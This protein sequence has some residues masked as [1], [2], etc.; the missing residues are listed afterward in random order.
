MASRWARFK[1]AMYWIHRWTGIG[2]CVLMALWF[3]SG[4]VMLFVGYPKL[5]PWERLHNMPALSQQCC[6]AFDVLGSEDL[7]AVSA[8]EFRLTT[9]DGTP[10]YRVLRRD[11]SYVVFD[12]MTGARRAAV[13]AP[14]SLRAAGD[15]IAVASAPARASA[16]YLGMV[17]EDTWTHSG[18]LN[19]HRPLHRVQLADA[20][21]T[22]V[23]VSSR[24]GEVVMDAPLFQ[25]AWNYV[26][27]WLHWLYMFRDR[28][29]DPVWSWLV[30]VLSGVGVVSATTGTVVGI[31]RWRFS[32]RYKSG[33][34]SPYR[35]GFMYW[36]HIIGLAAAAVIWTWI[37]S[38]LMSMNPGAVFSPSG[39]R[40]DIVA[41]R[42]VASG[43]TSSGD[44]SAVIGAHTTGKPAYGG[45]DL[46]PTVVLPA[47]YRA[48][49]APVE[50]QWKTLAGEP[51][52]LARNA[53]NDTR[54]VV[55]QSGALQVRERWPDEVLRRAMVNLLPVPIVSFDRIDH[56]D[57]YYYARQP[58]AMRGASERRLPALKA[59]FADPGATT[60]Y[61]D[62]FTGDVVMSLD[63]RQRVE[64]W[65][66]SFLHSWDLPWM[67]NS[68]WR[69][70]LL[71][72]LSVGGLVVC[73]TGIKIG[74]SR[75]RRTM[76]QTF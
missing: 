67:L 72:L 6:V 68:K 9:I 20:D 11:G 24:T 5:T 50:L 1:R 49:F 54:L 42:T 40:P 43:A 41:Y 32:G 48:G 33:S 8:R 23:Y 30:I 66:F 45:R 22:L 16:R 46:L 60:V 14:A 26:G 35:D 56:Y 10:A 18:A 44:G 63:R 29:I 12:A 51:Y 19:A 21:K 73:V 70:V 76:K 53:A 4:V 69:D 75:L 71:I 39:A 55:S 27:A 59:Q 58:E 34:H 62:A 7:M 38:G 31:W 25:R 37:F 47:L 52:V 13:D 17:Q 15:F 3:V 57:A 2:A 65:L 64:R 28:P 74:W 61:V 36:H